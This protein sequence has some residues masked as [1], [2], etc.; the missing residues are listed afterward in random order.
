MAFGFRMA[1][2]K[3]L[4]FIEINRWAY[5]TYKRNLSPE[6][7]FHLDAAKV[8]AKVLLESTGRPDVVIG[9]PPCR[10]FSRANTRR[11]GKK[12]PEYILPVIFAK[13]SVKL[14]P[15][16][17]VMEEVPSFT[18]YLREATVNCFERGGYC[19]REVLLNAADYG[20]P[21]FRRRYLMLAAEDGGGVLEE[22]AERLASASVEER[23]TVEEAIGD[24]PLEALCS[25]DKPVKYT[26]PPKTSFQKWARK[27]CRRTV[28]NHVTSRANKMKEKMRFIQPGENLKRAFHRLPDHLKADFKNLGSIHSNIYRRLDPKRPSITITHP[29]KT[30]IIHPYFDRIISVRE[31]SRLQSFPDDFV[32]KGPL[33]VMQQM[34]ADAVP[35]LLAKAVAE[36]LIKVLK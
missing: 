29:R 24:L 21:Q 19:V 20:V 18:K 1:G 22:V 27:S 8:R 16:I 3:P 9:G 34:V 6:R 15:K 11:N 7:G 2:F 26:G 12:H 31:A 17:I 28:H 25:K 14:K 23:V 33:S 13:L 30:V 35:P 32:F 36:T 5:E 4:A 10:P